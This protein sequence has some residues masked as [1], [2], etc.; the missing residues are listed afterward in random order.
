MVLLNDAVEV[1]DLANDHWCV[2][3]D[4]DL[5]DRRFVR[6]A[7]V[8]RDFFRHA[9]G[10]RGL[11]KKGGWVFLAPNSKCNNV[12]NPPKTTASPLTR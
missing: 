10:L 11:V 12:P 4:I 6:T 5:I 9:T 8:H 3:V 7:L 2:P 1:F